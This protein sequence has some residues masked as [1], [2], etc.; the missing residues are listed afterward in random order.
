MYFQRLFLSS[1]DLKALQVSAIS[2]SVCFRDLQHPSA[3]GLFKS[4]RFLS[5]KQ[6]FLRR[7]EM[8]RECREKTFV[9]ESESREISKKKN[10]SSVVH[11]ATTISST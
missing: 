8:P 1:S 2:F 11:E 7:W 10:F 3:E 4:S 5:V 9:V 6:V